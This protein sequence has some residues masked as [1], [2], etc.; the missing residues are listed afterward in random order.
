MLTTQ[1]I[2]PRRAP[3]R[4][5]HQPSGGSRGRTDPDARTED[6]RQINQRLTELTWNVP[7]CNVAVPFPYPDNV[8][9]FGLTSLNTFDWYNI[10]MADL[11]AGWYARTTSSAHARCR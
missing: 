7:I 6:F 11:L 8:P 4:P 1:T 3:S 5:A 10:Q 9:N 2:Q